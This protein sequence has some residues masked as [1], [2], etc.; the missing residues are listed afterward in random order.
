MAKLMTYIK[1]EK[2]REA[3][4][5]YQEVFGAENFGIMGMD[6]NS[7][8]A[9]GIEGDYGDKV[10]HAAFGVLG[11]TILASDAFGDK[12]N[13]GDSVNLFLDF[14]NEDSEDMAKLEKLYKDIVAHKDTKI[15]MKLEEQY[16]GGKMG[17]IEDKYGLKWTMHAQDYSKLEVK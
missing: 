10:V 15:L 13:Y 17:M 12:I 16:W 7:A 11:N 5:Y 6:E 14:N 8:K 4:A 2:T 3:I 1:F 9:M